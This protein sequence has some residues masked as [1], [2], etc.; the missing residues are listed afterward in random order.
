MSG[1]VAVARRRTALVVS[2]A[3]LAGCGG[4]GPTTP[5]SSTPSAVDNVAPLQVSSGPAGNTVNGLYASVTVCVPGTSRCQTIDGVEVDTGSVGLRLLSSEVG[6]SLPP[7]SD[8][9]GRPLGNCSSFVDKSYVWG[10]VVTADVQI[11]GEK[12]SAVPVQLV[13]DPGFA[14]APSACS[15]GGTAA[16]NVAALGAKGLLGLGLFRQDCGPACSGGRGDVPAVYFGCAGSA[17]SPTSVPLASQLQ[18]P[19]WLFPQDNNG[20]AVVLPSVP[21]DG[22]PTA[23]GSLV[24]GIGTEANNVLGSARVYTTDFQGNFTTTFDGQ[25]YPGSYLDTGSNGLFFLDASTIGLPPC[26]RRN[27]DFSCPAS[28][29]TYSATNTGANGAS[30]QVSFSVANAESLFRTANN[31]LGTLGGPDTGEFDWG[32]PFFFGRTTFVAIEGQATPGGPGPYWAY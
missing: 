17:C 16:N 8:P 31:A 28:T 9:G 27:S 12:A 1:C 14:D 6:L 3:T 20:V 13:S 29:V 18:N 4:Q 21:P 2:V 24:F 10:P 26:P 7:V 23:S 11:A 30:E 22:A 25:R 5:T 32:L 15:N 19:V